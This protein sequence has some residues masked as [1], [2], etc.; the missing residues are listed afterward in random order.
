MRYPAK[1]TQSF[2]SLRTALKLLNLFSIEEPELGIS[3]MADKLEV[4]RSTAFR[5]ANTLSEE[6][7]LVKDP[8]TKTYRL[9]ATILAKGNTIIS[10]IGLCQL[11]KSIIE[12]LASQSGETAHIAIY[13]DHQLMYLFKIDSSYPVHLLSHAGKLN[14]LHCTSTGQILLAHQDQNRINEVINKGLHDYTKNTLTDPRK[15]IELLNT[16]KKQ[17]Y[18]ISKEELHNGVSSIAAPVCDGAGKVIAAVSI[19]GPIARINSQTIP[20]L[21][22]LVQSAADEISRQLKY[23][24]HVKNQ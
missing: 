17:R 2:S 3:E 10:N 16:I 4:G 9:A 1:N 11:S 23:N 21:T 7:L 20:K 22:K 15:L 12:K 6:G 5:L 13:K 14:P 24:I 18:S 8:T 19:A